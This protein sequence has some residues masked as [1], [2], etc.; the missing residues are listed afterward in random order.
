MTSYHIN[1]L[2][3]TLAKTGHFCRV[4]NRTGNIVVVKGLSS[5]VT[6]FYLV[7]R[8]D[9]G[10]ALINNLE[11]NV[12]K[13]MEDCTKTTESKPKKIPKQMLLSNKSRRTSQN[14]NNQL[15]GVDDLFEL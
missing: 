4:S 14:A 12:E 9:S 2:S 1:P 15:D 8:T 3:N 7:F 10:P 11:T 5:A 13:S 6:G